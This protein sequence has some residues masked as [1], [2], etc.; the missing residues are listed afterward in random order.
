MTNR[1]AHFVGIVGG[2]F[3]ARAPRMRGSGAPISRTPFERGKRVNG[4]AGKRAPCGNGC[5]IHD[6]GGPAP[7]MTSIHPG[8]HVYPDRTSERTARFFRDHPTKSRSTARGS[9][10][11]CSSR[12]TRGATWPPQSQVRVSREPLPDRRHDRLHGLPSA[13]IRARLVP[14]SLLEPAV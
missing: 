6:A 1:M 5:T 2:S 14:A 7:L 13:D 8:A 10:T 11:A 12:P 3:M 4:V 9:A